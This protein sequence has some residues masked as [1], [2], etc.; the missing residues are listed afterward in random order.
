MASPTPL[1]LVFNPQFGAVHWDT[2]AK[3][4]THNSKGGII[5]RDENLAGR[6]FIFKPQLPGAQLRTMFEL[7]RHP[8]C[9]L[10]IGWAKDHETRQFKE[11][12]DDIGYPMMN[13][14]PR[15]T[16]TFQWM[17]AEEWG[18]VGQSAWFII[19]GGVFINKAGVRERSGANIDVYLNN[20]LINSSG[21]PE[22]LFPRGLDQMSIAIIN[23]DVHNKF[24]VP[25]A[26]KIIALDKTLD[27]HTTGWPAA[28]WEGPS[29]PVLG[30]P[31][32]AA[33]EAEA[34][35]HQANVEE[36]ITKSKRSSDRPWYALDMSAVWAWYTSKSTFT[37]LVF[38]VL[39]SASAALIL[40][41]WSR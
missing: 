11:V 40:W 38:M 37:Q 10:K 19:P 2:I 39:G 6:I 18:W 4:F 30:P 33:P 9:W 32:E 15:I 28:I 5:I 31:I 13:Y 8:S 41:A 14:F 24:K 35:V 17:D 27:K 22:P 3:G 1:T 23:R 7:G 12:V 26:G 25:Y 20:V 21:N 29:W 16:L 36:E 34:L